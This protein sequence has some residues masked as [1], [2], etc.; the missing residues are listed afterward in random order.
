ML[1]DFQACVSAAVAAEHSPR[2]AVSSE[3]PGLNMVGARERQGE[4]DE[5]TASM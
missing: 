4:K 3:A 1:R 5:R 2:R